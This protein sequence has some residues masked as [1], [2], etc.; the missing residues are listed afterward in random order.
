M[1]KQTAPAHFPHPAMVC[2]FAMARM[3]RMAEAQA[4]LEKVIS[5]LDFSDMARK[6]LFNILTSPGCDRKS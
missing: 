6:N 1:Q 2:A 4:E 5:S 3:G